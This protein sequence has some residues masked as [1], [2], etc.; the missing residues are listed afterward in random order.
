[1]DK[2]K[3]KLIKLLEPYMPK[4]LSEGCIYQRGDGIY[5]KYHKDKDLYET[6]IELNI[7]GLT[8][9]IIGHYD[10]CSVLK[11]IKQQEQFSF[12]FEEEDDDYFYFELKEQ[13]FN[14]DQK[15][16]SIPLKP[17][18]LY[19]EQEEKDLLELLLKLK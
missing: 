16:I 6:D 1:M 4:D 10:I 11:Y 13:D 3:L 7:R 8:V 18:H 19:S 9:K 15:T 2:T 5:L 12:M 14:W 17:L